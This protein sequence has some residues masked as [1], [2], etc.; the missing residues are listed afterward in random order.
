[1]ICRHTS[2][3][4]KIGISRVQDFGNFE[5]SPMFLGTKDQIDSFLILSS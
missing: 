3:S 1:M 2:T 4:F 5:I